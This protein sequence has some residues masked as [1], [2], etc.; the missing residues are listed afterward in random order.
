V[1]VREVRRDHAADGALLQPLAQ[2][3]DGRLELPVLE[4]QPHGRTRPELG[5]HVEDAAGRVDRWRSRLLREHVLAGAE[6]RLD[7][8]RH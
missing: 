6:R 2:P 7:R 1:V 8:C 3:A 4:H 5:D